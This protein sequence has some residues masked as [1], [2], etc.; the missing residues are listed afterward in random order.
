MHNINLVLIIRETDV[1]K[2]VFE[3]RHVANYAPNFSNEF[4]NIFDAMD[5]HLQPRLQSIKNIL[6]SS[7]TRPIW[8]PKYNAMP[9]LRNQVQHR[10]M[11]MDIQIIHRQK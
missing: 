7:V 4:E 11:T 10:R 6:D 5:V 1:N 9:A 2:V 8:C 3:R